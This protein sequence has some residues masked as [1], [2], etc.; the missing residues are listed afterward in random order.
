MRRSL[1]QIIKRTILA[2]IFATIC[3]IFGV[4]F[5]SS[6]E[7]L[8][9]LYDN[10]D[11]ALDKPIA[12][13]PGATAAAPLSSAIAEEYESPFIKV[14][15]HLIPSVVFIKVS[16][17]HVQMDGATPFGQPREQGLFDIPE[18]FFHRDLPDVESSGSGFIIS[19]D[20][21]ILTNNHV[22]EGASKITVVLSDEREVEG[23]IIG[24][25]PDTDVA[26]IKIDEN[27]D[28]ALVAPIGTSSELRVGQ[29]AIA[30]GN[31]YGLEHS[32]TVG[33]ISA[34]G[35]TNL[36]I[37]GGAPIYQNFIQTDASINFGNSG[38]PLVNIRGEVIGINTAINPMGQGLGFA[39]PIDMARK[40]YTDL[41]KFGAVE[42]GYLGMV[43]DKIS[44][45]FRQAL[46]LDENE[47][48]ILVKSVDS[49]TPA[50]I[51]GLLAGDVIVSW[52]GSPVTDVGDFRMRV[53]QGVPDEDVKAT[54]SRNGNLVDLAFVLGRRSEYVKRAKDDSQVSPDQQK[55]ILGLKVVEISNETIDR[56]G[57][58]QRLS[59][60]N[61]GVVVVEVGIFSPV[62]G[63]LVVGDV[64]TKI[65]RQQIN[66][67]E[68][69]HQAEKSLAEQDKTVLFHIIRGSGSIIVAITP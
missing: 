62:K 42:R 37:A 58:D 3:V 24:L 27:L 55:P 6:S 56:L 19:E 9:Y 5:A 26:V 29:W 10:K 25:D 69:F 8:S 22:V 28:E 15:D 20:G 13:T 7:M 66:N 11:V 61:Q 12:L 65:G 39:I 17:P 31:P 47:N 33:V 16:T 35:R 44:E 46:D 68:D 54:V 14:A 40:V 1:L 51:G 52:Q 4:I 49:N 18:M 21:Y 2:A 67:V 45:E 36:N 50:S 34:T 41:I 63:K 30:I 53:A 48:G 38:G 43:P 60:L 23:R 59:A 57:L 32:L 64:I